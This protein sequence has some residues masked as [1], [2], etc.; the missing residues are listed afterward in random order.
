MAACSVGQVVLAQVVAFKQNLPRFRVVQAGEQF[1]DGR[2]ARA[3]LPYQRHSLAGPD[4]K[5][6]VAQ[7]RRALARVGE[8]D[9]AELDPL[10]QRQL[11]GGAGCPGCGRQAR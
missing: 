5:A 1:D 11:A 2:L 8:A 3:V 10:A 7:G 6:H 9:V 4:A